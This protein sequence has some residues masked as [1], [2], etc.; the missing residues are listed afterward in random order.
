[1]TNWKYNNHLEQ[2]SQ[3]S[4][5]GVN[6]KIK[7][8]NVPTIL[9]RLEKCKH[10]NKRISPDVRKY[11]KFTSGMTTRRYIEIYELLNP[12]FT[13]IEYRCD[14]MDE[15]AEILDP[16][17]PEIV[18]EVHESVE[19]SA[20][21][22]KNLTRVQIVNIVRGARDALSERLYDKAFDLLTLITDN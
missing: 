17:T 19:H 16:N 6:Y 21:K 2:F 9:K 22:V 18:C 8:E 11:P 3:F 12:N 1:M 14:G 5:D 13:K 15:A 4:R 7:H 20:P 10:I